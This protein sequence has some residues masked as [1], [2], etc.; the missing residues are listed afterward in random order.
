[1]FTALLF[2]A[3]GKSILFLQFKLVCPVQHVHILQEVIKGAAERAAEGEDEDNDNRK[4]KKVDRMRLVTKN[5]EEGTEL[6]K[7]K[8]FRPA[9][10]RYHKALTHCAKFF[11]LNK[12][13]EAEVKALKLSLYLNL[14][15]CYIKLDN[16]EQVL[17]NC[18]EALQ[19]DPQNAKAL[20]R[21]SAYYESKRDWDNAMGD[22]KKCSK[23]NGGVE[24]KGVTSAME[25]IKKAMQNEKAKEKST[26]GKLFG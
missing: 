3:L 14:A 21:R 1:M 16:W 9:A 2:A 11:D 25:R 17:R 15:S 10:A 7:D 22:L 26:W 23:L 6:F 5:K 12:D 19:L 18:T 24:D 4:L 13:D 20:F 8:N